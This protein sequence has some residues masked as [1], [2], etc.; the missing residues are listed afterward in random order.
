MTSSKLER[1]KMPSMDVDKLINHSGILLLTSRPCAED[2]F[3]ASAP[4]MAALLSKA[5]VELLERLSP[6]E[7]RKRSLD[8]AE[9]RAHLAASLVALG[10]PEEARAEWLASAAEAAVC[11]RMLESERKRTPARQEGETEEDS[12]TRLSQTR[13]ESMSIALLLDASLGLARAGDLRSA[14]HC[15]LAALVAIF[16]WRLPDP[17]VGVTSLVAYACTL[18]ADELAGGGPGGREWLP[19]ERSTGE[20]LE[21][22][23][24]AWFS[25]R[26][27]KVDSSGLLRST[28]GVRECFVRYLGSAVIYYAHN[29]MGLPEEVADKEGSKGRDNAPFGRG[30]SWAVELE[31]LPSEPATL[32]SCLRGAL[33]VRGKSPRLGEAIEVQEAALHSLERLLGPGDQ[34]T[35]EAALWLASTL[36]AKGRPEHASELTATAADAISRGSNALHWLPSARALYLQLIESHR[37][38]LLEVATQEANETEAARGERRVADVKAMAEEA[39]ATAEAV[40]NGCGRFDCGAPECPLTCSVRIAGIATAE[41]HLVHGWL[42][43]GL[44]DCLVNEAESLSAAGLHAR[45]VGRLKAALALLAKVRRWGGNRARELGGIRIRW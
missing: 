18:G 34:L 21:E 12:R 42:S 1:S 3:F 8:A 25:C 28:C 17:R 29:R 15:L 11:L 44:A 39:K 40:C 7:R 10:K 14:F 35:C 41:A 23:L 22:E 43:L 9:A 2:S 38:S 33:L 6:P 32:L 27:E 45:A 20:R 31:V 4:S 36:R 16:A 37:K 26:G 30:A 24:A 13:I 19:A 5:A